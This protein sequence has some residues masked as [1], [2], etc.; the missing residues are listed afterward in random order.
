M[1][2]NSSNNN[3]IPDPADIKLLQRPGLMIRRLHQI[4]VSVFLSHGREFDLTPI[5]YGSIQIVAIFPGIHQAGLGKLLALD[6]QTISNVVKRL[7][8]KG[9]LIRKKKDA[10]TSAL[11]A[12]GA[13][14]A[15]IEV[16]KE[17]LASVDD[18]IL[19]PLSPEE[20]E[21]FMSLLEK[22][23]DNNNELSRAPS[24]GFSPSSTSGKKIK[25]KKVK[26]S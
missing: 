2:N 9:L 17:R 19:G 11:F 7:S 5:Q 25:P 3:A 1:T 24:G 14:L 13:A 6:R 15:L 21:T 26:E 12:S 10:R 23:V 20:R 4:A 18:I 22:L 8:D 16:M